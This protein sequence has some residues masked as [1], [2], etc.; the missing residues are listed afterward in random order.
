M[1]DIDYNEELQ[2][3]AK[4]FRQG[5]PGM[6]LCSAWTTLVSRGSMLLEEWEA[7]GPESKQDPE[8]WNKVVTFRNIE[9]KL[10][11]R[12]S[13]YHPPTEHYWP[14]LEIFNL[15]IYVC[16][17]FVLSEC[18]HSILYIYLGI[19][20]MVSLCSQI[21][22]GSGDASRVWVENIRGKVSIK[23]MKTY[24]LIWDAESIFQTKVCFYSVANIVK[25]K[26]S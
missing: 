10:D 18:P 17:L 15:F 14:I 1:K 7:G 25:W 12:E 19:S 4:Y 13:I 26:I 9:K 16:W 21:K 5:A 23:G 3:A 6:V 22:E 20:C 2:N 8:S 24:T 11:L